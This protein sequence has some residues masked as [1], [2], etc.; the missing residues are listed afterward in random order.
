M[1]VQENRS[2]SQQVLFLVREYLSRR[3]R[4]QAEK[5]SAIRLLQLAGSWEDRRTASEIV[6]DLRAARKNSGRLTR[7]L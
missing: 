4:G 1:A 3:G 7:G 6:A 5:P 2:V